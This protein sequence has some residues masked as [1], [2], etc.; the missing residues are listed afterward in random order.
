M[1]DNDHASSHHTTTSWR[2]AF[3]SLAEAAPKEYTPVALGF[4]LVEVVARTWFEPKHSTLLAKNEVTP[5][6]N[7]SLAIRPLLLSESGNWVKKSLTWR[8]IDRMARQFDVDPRH[9][10]W[11]SQL[12][13][14]RTRD[15]TDFTPDGAPYSLG[16]FRTPLLWEMFDQGTALGIELVGVNQGMN[17]HIGRH[18]KAVVDVNRV[19][20][21][22][23]V[24]PRATIDEREFAPGLI[25]PIWTHGFFGVDLRSGFTVTLAPTTAST[26][27]SAL[28]VF[29]APGP[30]TIPNDEAEEFFEEYYPQLRN[31]T[32]VVST[33]ESVKFP[34]F[35]QPRL[36]LF[37][38]FGVSDQ[39][40]L[41]W[42]WEYSGPRRTLP[43]ALA[44]T[45]SGHAARENRDLEHEAGVTRD[46]EAHLADAS[47]PSGIRDME[48]TDADTADFVV[49]VLPGLEDIEHVKVITRG[50][51][52]P[53]R[54]LGGEPNVKITSVESEKND[55]FDLGFQI[56]VDGH[57]VPFVKLFKALAAGTK[58]IKLSD[59]TFL[60]LNKPVFDKIKALLAEADL[61]PEWEPE[62][63]KI[64]RLQVGLWSEFEDLADESEPA[65]S[66]RESALALADLDHLPAVEV[67]PLGGVT[68]RPYQ[69]QGFRW[70]ALLHR[71][72]LGGILADDMGLGKTLQ[73]LALIAHAKAEHAKTAH[74]NSGDVEPHPPFLVV[75]PT[76]VVGN[77]AKEAAKF[78]P[79]LDVRVVAE[80]T[81]KRKK[82]LAEVVD[83]ADV[84]VMSYAMLRLDEDPISDLT[85]SGF[86]L[87][88]A[89]F[90]KNSSSQVHQAATSVNAPFRLALTGTPL[91]NS[92][93]D[94]WSLFSITAPGLFPSA[95]RFE[96]EYVRPI[97]GGEN[98]GRM[99]RLQR[100]IRPFMLRRSKDLVA[101][102]LPQKQEQVI[103]VELNSEHRKLYD[104]VLQ[105]ER[106]KILGFIDSEYDKQRFIVFRSLTLLRMLA[107][108]PRIVDVEHEGVASSK[109]AALMERLEDVVAE[110]HRS[111]VFS[112][113]TSFLDKVAEDLDRR[114]VPYVVLDGSTRKRETIIDEFRTGAA[115]VFLISLKA[116]GFGLN[117]TEADYVF[118]MDPWWNPAT[119]NQAIDRAHRIGQTKSVM[120][121]RYVAEGT[122]EEKVLALQK[123]KAELFDSLMSDG[124]A[125]GG[126]GPSGQAFSQTV[127]ADDIRGLLEG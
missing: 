77:W 59:D 111:I 26:R 124:G 64:S 31:S 19:Q 92:L 6:A 21:Q 114:G 85:W 72:R 110:G 67:P 24:Q 126:R 91:E 70:L 120:V 117:L 11:F 35:S 40:S 115:P 44:A 123:R 15:K 54:E 13:G 10:E 90:V 4:E 74:A 58:K 116:G 87:D 102:D 7:P 81:K 98:P 5:G 66:W 75:A 18:A 57:P 112:Q 99:T 60:S 119:E 108:D 51:K 61:V 105:K 122:I 96:E 127:T 93:R 73:T 125:F 46:V 97:E 32:E 42:Y 53:Y 29:N 25:K 14:L 86:V 69:V 118:L 12:A 106:K 107:L 28:S 88:E 103:N 27:E 45:S 43:V 49:N 41:E 47:F 16:D 38:K 33:D 68:M 79:D 17:I 37:L 39:V 78:T 22:L 62:S 50:K 113:F 3:A 55:W 95:H 94:L 80:S 89:Q 84:I 52:Q 36:V 109:L 83:G 56:T 121:Y 76:S 8:N 48:L 82:H 100:R 71:C 104:R 63:P 2:D 1:P 20:G 34:Q 101:A 9:Q 65:Q 23:R 30:I